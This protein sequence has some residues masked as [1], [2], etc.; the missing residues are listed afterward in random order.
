MDC[1][2]APIRP[3]ISAIGKHKVS[4]TLADLKDI[5]CT[6]ILT[7]VKSLLTRAKRQ[8]GLERA[9][10]VDRRTQRRVFTLE[11]FCTGKYF[12]LLKDIVSPYSQKATAWFSVQPV[13]E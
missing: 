2:I 10:L 4:A 1:A 6:C 12:L 13:G 3:Q 5:S 9:V 11:L 7:G 8:V